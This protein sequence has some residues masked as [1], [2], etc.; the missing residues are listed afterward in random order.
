MKQ[1]KLTITLLAL[2]VT[3]NLFAQYSLA[4]QHYLYT[5]F[6]DNIDGT[7]DGWYT[8]KLNPWVI[9]TSNTGIATKK[10]TNF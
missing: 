2:I 5:D 1:K 10:W 7:D 4:I 6:E 9:D 8:S 3:A